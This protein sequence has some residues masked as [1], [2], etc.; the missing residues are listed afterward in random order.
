MR[1]ER[2]AVAPD[3]GS[4]IERHEAKGL[5]RGRRDHLPRIDLERVTELRQLVDHG[6][7]DRAE[8]VLEQLA[9]LGNTGGTGR[10]DVLDDRLIEGG[11]N[12]CAVRR[13][14]SDDLRNVAGV[15]GGVPRIDPLR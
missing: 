2:D 11:G 8:G 15:V 3:P 7:I 14:A 4:R 10:V 12:L 5:G 6:D 13:D 9:G 1:V